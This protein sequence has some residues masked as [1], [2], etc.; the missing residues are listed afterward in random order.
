[1]YQTMKHGIYYTKGDEAFVRV[2]SEPLDEADLAY[3]AHVE[4]WHH[5]KLVSRQNK[6]CIPYAALRRL[7]EK[8][9]KEGKSLPQVLAELVSLV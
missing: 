7:V 1:M 5:G 2:D 4:F 6:E 9:E 3:F 8:M